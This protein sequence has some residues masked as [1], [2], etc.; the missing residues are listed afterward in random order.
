MMVLSRNGFKVESCLKRL[1]AIETIATLFSVYVNNNIGSRNKLFL[2]M[3]GCL[4][5]I[6][7]LLLSNL[8]SKILPDNRDLYCILVTTSVKIKNLIGEPSQYE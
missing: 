4:V 2:V 8:L 7:V 5:T 1:S 3:T 6:P